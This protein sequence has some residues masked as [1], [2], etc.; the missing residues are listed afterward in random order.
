MDNPRLNAIVPLSKQARRPTQPIVPI[1]QREVAACMPLVQSLIASAAAVV[2]TYVTDLSHPWVLGLSAAQHG[3]PLVLVG[4]GRRWGGVAVKLPAARRAV[5]LLH[6]GSPDTPIVFADGT[7]TFVT[8]PLTAEL[9]GRLRAASSAGSVLVQAECNSWP[10]CYANEYAQH[11]AFSSCRAR[12][13][14]TCFPNS[15]AF[16]GRSETLLRF[17]AALERMAAAGEGPEHLDDQAALHRLYLR[18]SDGIEVHVDELS[19]VFLG[20]HAC[21]GSGA[22]RTFRVRGASFSMC[23]AGPYDPFSHVLPNGSRLSHRRSRHPNAPAASEA[24]GDQRGRLHAPL[25]AHAHGVHDRILRALW[26]APGVY[27]RPLPPELRSPPSRSAQWRAT[28]DSATLL[29][30]QVLLI[31]SASAADGGR[32]DGDARG[33]LCRLT[34]LRELCGGSNYTKVQG[35]FI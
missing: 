19:D 30:H 3:V 27:G 14:S 25:L 6:A 26:G 22:K 16:A 32:A 17:L 11:A 5:Q 12:H 21:K 18:S 9:A 24:A 4:H 34:S 23:H 13:S 33:D 28:Y 10:R 1:E 29:D 35:P 7:D 31:D 20:L 15:G 2:V 8:N